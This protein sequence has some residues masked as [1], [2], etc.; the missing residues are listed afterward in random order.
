MEKKD[1][2]SESLKPEE[3]Q[4]LKDLAKK[5]SSFTDFAIKV[6]LERVRLTNTIIRGSGAPDTIEIIRKFLYKQLQTA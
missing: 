3:I 6:Q 1:K 2:R 4:L 5:E